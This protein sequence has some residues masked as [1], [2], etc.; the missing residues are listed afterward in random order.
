MARSR[1]SAGVIL[2]NKKSWLMTH[3][4]SL[5]RI[6]T[7]SPHS[8]GTKGLIHPIPEN[9]MAAAAEPLLHVWQKTR[10]SWTQTHPGLVILMSGF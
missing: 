7:S 4:A 8:Q 3:H 2:P 9:K 1:G 10:T 6:S 5:E